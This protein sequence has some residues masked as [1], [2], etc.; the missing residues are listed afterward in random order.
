M[1][2]S[3]FICVFALMFCCFFH[4][5][6]FL[7]YLIDFTLLLLCPYHNL[8]FNEIYMN[9]QT[10]FQHFLY[11]YLFSLE[12]ASNVNQL[13]S[14]FC[15]C[16]MYPSYFFVLFYFVYLNSSRKIAFQHPSS[17]PSMRPQQSV[18]EILPTR[19]PLPGMN[20]VLSVFFF[21]NREMRGLII[22]ICLFI[23]LCY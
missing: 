7:F 3:P 8:Q 16:C 20:A 18:V 13:L 1:C 14:F 22:T 12:S 23:N 21:G 2:S 9:I 17:S 4:L 15:C 19:R 10:T 11:F 6:T 5:S